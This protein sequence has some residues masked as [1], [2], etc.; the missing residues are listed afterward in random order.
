M[1]EKE[2]ELIS[3]GTYNIRNTTD[4]YHE[5]K[6][7]L[8][9]I[10]H[11]DYAFDVCGLQE[12]RF[13]ESHDFL[14]QTM[15]LI[16]S[17]SYTICKTTL[18]KPFLSQLDPN[19][20]IDGNCIIFNSLKY[21]LVSEDY[22]SLSETR[23]AQRVT[24]R[25]RSS[26]PSSPPLMLSFTNVHLHHLLAPEDALI[27]LE[28][29]QR[30]IEWITE[31]DHVQAVSISILVGDFNCSPQEIGYQEILSA[32]YA[33]AYA[34]S[35]PTGDEPTLTFPTGLQASTMDTD[36][37]ITCDYIFLKSRHTDSTLAIQS[38]HLFGNDP[39]PDD[40]TV[41]PSDHIGILSH[42]KIL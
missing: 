4:R 1:A 5:R 30:T 37:P 22:L 19:F 42:V 31:L 6:P 27:R 28:Q 38:C 14:D 10:F 26:S 39:S 34:L 9:Q 29:I 23:N 18:N 11:Q 16:P 25:S 21:D 20:R 2:A 40:P 33:S 41:Y 8:K 24:L 7:L 17:S 13:Y 12:V 32:G 36:P 35:S 15:D 3:L